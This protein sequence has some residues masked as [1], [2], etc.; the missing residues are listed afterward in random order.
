MLYFLCIKTRG[1]ANDVITAGGPTPRPTRPIATGC[2]MISFSSPPDL[3]F[4]DGA[5]STWAS[6]PSG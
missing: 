1:R 2:Y 5:G 4:A 3:T 6:R